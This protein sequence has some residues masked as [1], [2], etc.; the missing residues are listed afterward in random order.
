MALVRRGGYR[1]QIQE[2]ATRLMAPEHFFNQQLLIETRNSTA[3][4][5]DTETVF[6]RDAGKHVGQV[7]ANTGRRPEGVNRLFH[8][9]LPRISS[10][11]TNTARF[12]RGV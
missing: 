4:R 9:V 12:I 3:Q 7:R 10:E 6:A 2:G 5:H 11:L 1:D 8:D